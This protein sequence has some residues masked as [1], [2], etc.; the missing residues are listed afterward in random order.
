MNQAF[1][2]GAPVAQVVLYAENDEND[3]VLMN[4]CWRRAKMAQRLNVVQDGEEAIRYLSG[5]GEFADRGRFPLPALVL[6]DLSMPRCS[7]L[8]V[9]A[10]VRAR[11]EFVGL[12]VLIV[13]MSNQ[14]KD[15]SEAERLGADGYFVK[16]VGLLGFVETVQGWRERWLSDAGSGVGE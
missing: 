14:E 1:Q 11:P 3:A 8:E 9:L 15:R 12:P 6:L 13:S 4:L 7:G 5:E 16:P 10:W 2:S